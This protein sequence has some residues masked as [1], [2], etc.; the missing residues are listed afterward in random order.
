MNRPIAAVRIPTHV[1]SIIDPDGA[2]LLDLKQGQY[3]SLNGIGA[4]VW[5]KLQAGMSADRIVST[6]GEET[7]APAESV[8]A[9]VRRFLEHLRARHLVDFDG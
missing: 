7:N 5:T 6:L 8:E 2:V 4:D 9:D 3:Y 1:R